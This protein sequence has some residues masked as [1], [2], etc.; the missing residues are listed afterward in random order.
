MSAEPLFYLDMLLREQEV[1]LEEVRRLAARTSVDAPEE[2]KAVWVVLIAA[3][4]IY[5][6][7]TQSQRCYILAYLRYQLSRTGPQY[8]PPEFD[9]RKLKGAGLDEIIGTWL[10][11]EEASAPCHEGSRRGKSVDYSALGRT[12]ARLKATCRQWWEKL[13]GSPPLALEGGE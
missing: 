13:F 5:Q 9:P 1:D 3:V 8:R 12:E 2:E 10:T 11:W 6:T 7:G 4:E